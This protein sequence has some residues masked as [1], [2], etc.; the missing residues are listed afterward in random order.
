[1][2]EECRNDVVVQT[3][4]RLFRG[5]R[6]RGLG[7]LEMK[8]DAR[9]GELL[10]VEPNIGRPTGR[11]AGAEAAGV[12][13]LYTMYADVLGLPLPTNREQQYLGRKWIY[14]RSD[15]QSALYHWRRGELG[16]REWFRSWRGL[17]SDA[18]FSLRDPLPFVLD[19]SGVMLELWGVRDR[20]SARR[21]RQSQ[22]REVAA[23]ASPGKDALNSAA[24]PQ[25][26]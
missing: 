18:L 7:Y 24:H 26:R 19:S 22:T 15:L 23:T 21:S 14:F 12:E 17:A 20:R 6:H 8:R 1:L 4:I 5:A 9:T 11:S 3:T 2:S 13:L 16:L 25:W 10:I